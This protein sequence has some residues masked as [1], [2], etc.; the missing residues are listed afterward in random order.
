MKSILFI[1]IYLNLIFQ[2]VD[3]LTYLTIFDQ[4]F[5]IPREKKNTAYREYLESLSSYLEDYVYR[6]APLL[7]L[8]EEQERT[9]KQFEKNWA[10]GMFPGWGKEASSALAHSGA[11]LDLSAF[12]SWEELASL[13]LDRLKSALMALGLKCGGTLEQRAQRLWST[14]GKSMEEL[15]QSLFAKAKPGKAGKVK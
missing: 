7:D 10:E 13:G 15:D 8:S 4:L 1:F 2:R 6:V 14:K 12:S 5:D 11:H 3:Y 9:R